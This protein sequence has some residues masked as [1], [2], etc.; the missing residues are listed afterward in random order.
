MIII[1]TN[2]ELLYCRDAQSGN[3]P[4]GLHV[5]QKP[6]PD[7]QEAHRL[8]MHLPCP[9]IRSRPKMAAGCQAA[10]IRQREVASEIAFIVS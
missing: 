8:F 2:S 1:D 5:S 6:A 10:V 4:T 9:F 3:Q 7:T